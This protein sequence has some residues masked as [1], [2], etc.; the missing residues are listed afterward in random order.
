[1]VLVSVCVVSF[2]EPLALLRKC[3]DS[4]R[5]TCSSYEI[6]LVNNNP[7]RDLSLLKGPALTLLQNPS[8]LGFA[9]ACNQAVKASRGRYVLF[10]NSDAL[11]QKHAL[12]QM[13]RLLETRS[14]VG[15]VGPA[16]YSPQGRLQHSTH[17]FITLG[18]VFFELSGLSRLVPK[19]K[20]TSWL[21]GEFGA[22]LFPHLLANY[23]RLSRPTPVAFVSGA[24]FLTRKE[25]FVRVGPFDE[26]FF[27][28][29]E[30][31]EWHY[32]L[33]KAGLKC[34]Y[35]PEAKVVHY[36]R[37]SVRKEEGVYGYRLSSLS[38][39]FEAHL[40]SRRLVFCLVATLSILIHAVL[41]VGKKHSLRRH[42]EAVAQV[43]Q[44]RR[45]RG[46]LWRMRSPTGYASPS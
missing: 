32:R 41:T 27:L 21:L 46:P 26:A 18:H 30:E 3:L 25:T 10:L 28:Y 44:S 31:M 12:A 11:L 43:W 13:L 7:L 38:H 8:N 34:M 5:E 15:S 39:F 19:N 14:D 36:G 17:G 20:V 9:R 33:R 16:L 40:K 6:V 4:V 2:K 42:A 22:Q 1:M 35:L 24:C 23:R 45:A 29:H 37:M